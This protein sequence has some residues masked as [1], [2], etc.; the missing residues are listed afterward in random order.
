MSNGTH[1]EPQLNHYECTRLNLLNEH[2]VTQDQ[3]YPTVEY[4]SDMKKKK[5]KEW[6]IDPCY[7]VDEP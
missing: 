1:R 6:S 3:E 5:K 4:Y 7:N 2:G